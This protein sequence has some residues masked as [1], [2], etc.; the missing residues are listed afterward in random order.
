MLHLGRLLQQAA[1]GRRLR[2]PALGVSGAAAAPVA[3]PD[4]DAAG[5]LVFCLLSGTAAAADARAS[6]QSAPWQQR[7]ERSGGV[8]SRKPRR[9]VVVAQTDALH[10]APFDIN[11]YSWLSTR[12]LFSTC[13]SWHADGM[14]LIAGPSSLQPGRLPRGEGFAAGLGS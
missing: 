13:M 9:A 7:G 14:S 6:A 2:F 5:L 4:C 8:A 3:A 11:A 12:L 10:H 1:G